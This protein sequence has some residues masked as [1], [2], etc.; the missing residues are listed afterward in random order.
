MPYV[1]GTA[2]TLLALPIYWFVASFTPL[3]YALVVIVLFASGVWICG[4]AEKRLGIH[5]HPAVVWDEIV[6]FLIAMFGARREWAWV[7]AGFVLFRLFDIWKPYPIRQLERRVRG[8]L[9]TMLDDALAGLY[10]WACLQLAY[11]LTR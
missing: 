4:R 11:T 5:D 8:G 10:A 1:P 3:A 9:G 2:G 7:A 6:G